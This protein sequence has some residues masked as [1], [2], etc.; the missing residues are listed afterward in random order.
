MLLQE[1]KSEEGGVTSIPKAVSSKVTN[2]AMKRV[3]D[4]DTM[5]GS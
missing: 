5:K 1:H 4:F 3:S 2:G